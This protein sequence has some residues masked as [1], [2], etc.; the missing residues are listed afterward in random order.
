MGFAAVERRWRRR[1]TKMQSKF[2][3]VINMEINHQ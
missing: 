2:D 1:E 3:R